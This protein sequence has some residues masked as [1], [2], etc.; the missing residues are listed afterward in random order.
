MVAL[1]ARA[2]RRRRRRL[3]RQLRAAVRWAYLTADG[4]LLSVLMQLGEPELD[5]LAERIA[6]GLVGEE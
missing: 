2:R 3:L 5:E 4:Y 1:D 6:A